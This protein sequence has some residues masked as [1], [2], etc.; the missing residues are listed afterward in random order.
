MKTVFPQTDK[1]KQK[2]D[3]FPKASCALDFQA[4]SWRNRPQHFAVGN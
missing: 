1:Q 2:V 3:F 4:S